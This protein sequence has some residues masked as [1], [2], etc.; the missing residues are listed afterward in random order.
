M[1][2]LGEEEGQLEELQRRLQEKR[3]ACQHLREEIAATR[4]ECDAAKGSCL[5]GIQ[6]AKVQMARMSAE[7]ATLRQ[8]AEARAAASALAA[9]GSE[10]ADPLTASASASAGLSN[11]GSP[12]DDS[13]RH[14]ALQ[15]EARTLRHELSKWKHQAE[16]LDAA[17]Q[18]QEREI[19]H[20]KA[21]LTHARDV[22]DS[23][24][25]AVRHHEVERKL[26]ET[27]LVPF[28]EA[29]HP[30]GSPSS[31]NDLRAMR[32]SNFEKLP[33]H[34][35]IEAKAERTIRERTEDRAGVL[36]SKAQKLMSVVS[37]QQ[38]LIQRLEKQLL[39]EEDL[40]GQREWQLAEASKRH[41]RVKGALRKKSDGV[42]A[43]ALGVPGSRKPSTSVLLGAS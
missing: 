36:S 3:A 25:L 41:S 19:A 39:K 22:L 28:P 12:A 17:R 15:M 2:P 26:R 9:E 8:R 43:V 4:V 6:A 33:R 37:S 29:G 10:G 11:S 38:L 34:G 30:G 21:N 5:A 42:V 7:L 24:R 23:T 31:K 1:S 18:G 20:L 27:A 32:G 35:S 13:L 16:M 14:E 40:L